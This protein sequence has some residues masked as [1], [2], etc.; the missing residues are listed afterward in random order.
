MEGMRVGKKIEKGGISLDEFMQH[1]IKNFDELYQDNKDGLMAVMNS[2]AEAQVL[3][4]KE[5][6]DIVNN[7]LPQEAA[8][9][10]N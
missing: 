10:P 7:R 3:F 5:L 4:S 1:I 8:Q 2:P 9:R 6:Q